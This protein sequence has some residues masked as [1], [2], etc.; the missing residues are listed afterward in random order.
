LTNINTSADITTT[1]NVNCYSVNASYALNAAVANV[2]GPLTANSIASSTSI[3]SGNIIQAGTSIGSSSF[4]AP[5]DQGSFMG[6]NREGGSGRTSFMTAQGWGFGGWEW[7]NYDRF[8]NLTSPA[9]CMT[10]SKEGDLVIAGTSSLPQV[11]VKKI[12][13]DSAITGATS[14]Y[15]IYSG[16]G[17][18]PTVTYAMTDIGG[19]F[20]VVAGSFP[21][22]ASY[23]FAYRYVN[24]YSQAPIICFSPTNYLTAGIS[25]NCYVTTTTN[26]LTF[27]ISSGGAM[28]TGT[29]NRWNF[30]IIQCV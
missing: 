18:S 9:P 4:A 2:T 16:C 28:T 19:Y 10:L 26:E 12:I 3:T 5:Y 14:K 17:S 1:R 11:R 27:G 6:W 24:A 20:Q 22:A 15:T 23:F 29:T 8:L 7:V 25:S 30:T 13:S 21:P